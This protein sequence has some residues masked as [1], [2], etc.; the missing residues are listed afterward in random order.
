MRRAG[1]VPINPSD[2]FMSGDLRE[3]RGTPGIQDARV[4]SVR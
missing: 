2:H 3:T 1:D 4:G